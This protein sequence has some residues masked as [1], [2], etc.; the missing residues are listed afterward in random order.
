MVPKALTAKFFTHK[1][2][3]DVRYIL[4]Q[5]LIKGL[6][7]AC[8]YVKETKPYESSGLSP[9]ELKPEIAGKLNGVTLAILEANLGNSGQPIFPFDKTFFDNHKSCFFILFHATP[10]STL[11][12]VHDCENVFMQDAP[13]PRIPGTQVV[14]AAQK[15]QSWK[16]GN[17][18]P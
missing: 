8:T 3:T 9:V 11:S 4:A 17:N 1:S 6:L 12:F 7:P 13:E 18:I 15:W 16:H 10:T 2:E 14:A 5:R